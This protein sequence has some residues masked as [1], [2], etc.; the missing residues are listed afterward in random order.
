VETGSPPATDRQG[1]GFEHTE[2]LRRTEFAAQL[3]RWQQVD[4][5]LADLMAV[6]HD[7][8]AGA[9]PRQPSSI[10]LDLRNNEWVM[11]EAADVH[12]VEIDR[13][14]GVPATGYAGYSALQAATLEDGEAAAPE[15]CRALESGLVT[16][17]NQRVVFHGTT[18]REWSFKALLRI[19]HSPVR[20]LTLIHVTDRR[21]VS[22]LEYTAPQAPY[23]RFMLTL[24]TV[25][26]A[27]ALDGFLAQLRSEHEQH[28]LMRPV[29]PRTE[30]PE[31][32]ATPLGRA[33]EVLLSAF[34]WWRRQPLLF[35]AAGSVATLVL[36]VAVLVS[37]GS[38]SDTPAADGRTAVQPIPEPAPEVTSAPPTGGVTPTPSASATVSPSPTATV[39]DTS[40]PTPT[41]T[42]TVD[43]CGAPA[44]PYGYNFC[45]RGHLLHH[46]ES[47]VCSYFTCDTNFGKTPGYLVQCQDGTLSSGGGRPGACARHHGVGQTVYS[48]P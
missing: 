15:P 14:P 20:P 39:S 12:L 43:L 13:V 9:W 28:A 34:A 25:Y 5:H 22:G 23:L 48:G 38:S 35:R 7:C 40:T 3:V 46:W 4:D 26:H 16:I 19:E 47:G 36:V 1:R 45:G 6:A 31:E 24:A 44:N 8:A 11:Y 30:P 21:W 41:P 2:R 32:P 18:R 37:L 17:T 29:P 10:P 42:R 33:R 27:G